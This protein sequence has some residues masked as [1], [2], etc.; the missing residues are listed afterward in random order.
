MNA[1]MSESAVHCQL[2]LRQPMRR[3]GAAL[4]ELVASCPPLDLNSRYAYLL[5]CHH[6]AGSS[7]IAESGGALVGAITAYVPPAQPDTLFVWQV[8]VAPHM[9]GQ[10]LGAHMLDHLGHQWLARR[11]LRW[12]ET[13]ISPGNGPS[14]KLFTGFARRH[15]VGCT[16]ATLFSASDFGESGHE[17]ECLYKIGPWD[18]AV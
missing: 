9:Q 5:F 7:V 11:Q 13:T 14:Q 10:G 3:D 18:R 1:R 15:G 17:E 16:T 2:T 4:H 8:A 12:L 6:N